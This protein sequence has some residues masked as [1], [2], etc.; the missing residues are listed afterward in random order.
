MKNKIIIIAVATVLIVGAGAFYGGM[1]YQQG[2][3][4]S[5]AQNFSGQ[6]MRAGNGAG[7]FQGGVQGG[8]RGGAQAGAGFINGEIIAKDD[9]S[10]TIKLGDGGSKIVFYS[11][12]TQM[13]KMAD[14]SLGDLAIGQQVVANGTVNSDGSVTAKTIQLRPEVIA[15]IGSAAAKPAGN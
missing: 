7:N 13:Q 2:K 6:R 1:K 14:M 3:D 9:K 15:P 12:S 4:S 5:L 10:V 8:G 11:A